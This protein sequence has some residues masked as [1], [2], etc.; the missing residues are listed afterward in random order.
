MWGSLAY[1]LLEDIAVI[2]F[3][4]VLVEYSCWPLVIARESSLSAVGFPAVESTHTR[5]D[6]HADA[7]NKQLC[8]L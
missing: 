1:G 6:S 2:C 3:T 7:L 4:S 8:G 5:R